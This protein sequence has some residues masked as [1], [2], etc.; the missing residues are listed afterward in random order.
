M[1]D[2][3]HKNQVYSECVTENNGRRTCWHRR[4][5]KIICISFIVLT[6][7]ALILSLVLK[8]AV[9]KSEKLE[10]ATITA[11]T[12]S[13]TTA[14]TIPHIVITTTAAQQLMT[15]ATAQQLMTT[16]LPQTTST[17]TTT[18]SSGKL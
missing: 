14:T 18:Q 2:N 10:T 11:I 17:L 7:F 8:F 13:L 12:S 16:R 9:F 15:T 3:I 5:V 6:I 4:L 1:E